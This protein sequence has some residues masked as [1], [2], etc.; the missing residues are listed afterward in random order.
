M[1]RVKHLQN[2]ANAL[3]EG[4]Q[5]R[6]LNKGLKLVQEIDA[7]RAEYNAMTEKQRKSLSPET[8][9]FFGDDAA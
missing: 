3:P 9:A 2:K 4:K 6:A 1:S 5:K 7:A 8:R